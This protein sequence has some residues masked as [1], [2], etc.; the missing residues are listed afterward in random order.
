VSFSPLVGLVT[1]R[2][3]MK[4]LQKKMFPGSRT[5]STRINSI[6]QGAK[7]KLQKK[8]FLVFFQKLTAKKHAF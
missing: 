1:D 6:K 3:L 7:P 4:T 2:A 5:N 8:N